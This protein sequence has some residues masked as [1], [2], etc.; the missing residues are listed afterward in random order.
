MLV[1]MDEQQKIVSNAL[2][3]LIW[4]YS[5]VY[6]MKIGQVKIAQFSKDNVM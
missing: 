6:V 1:V 2:N 4:I 3:M 5:L